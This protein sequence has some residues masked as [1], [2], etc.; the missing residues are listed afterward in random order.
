MAALLPVYTLTGER[1]RA[2]LYLVQAQV[3]WRRT[4]A[5]TEKPRHAAAVS[6]E[7]A[8]QGGRNRIYYL[9]K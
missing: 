2:V 3:Q 9:K 5:L 4:G 8:C 7:T 1:R 6:G